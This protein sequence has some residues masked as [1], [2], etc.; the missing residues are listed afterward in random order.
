VRH[1]RPA[2]LPR[3]GAEPGPQGSSGGD[4]AFL[5]KLVAVSFAGAAALKYGSLFLSAPFHPDSTLAAAMVILPTAAYGAILAV[6]A[7]RTVKPP[8][9][10]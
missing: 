7:G 6:E 10:G 1:C 9:R 5:A 8:P 4:A 3:A 2:L